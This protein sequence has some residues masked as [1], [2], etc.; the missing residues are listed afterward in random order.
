METVTY[1]VYTAP[2]R[3][4]SYI[5]LPA[6]GMEDIALIIALLR[7]GFDI[8]FIRCLYA[9]IHQWSSTYQQIDGTTITVKEYGRYDANISNIPLPSPTKYSLTDIH[10]STTKK[11]IFAAKYTIKE[12]H[13]ILNITPPESHKAQ[14]KVINWDT[15]AES[16]EIFIELL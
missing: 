3:R 7:Q 6:H 9:G 12:I 16:P 15:I 4:C 11:Q 8:Q 1:T 5:N 10:I 2:I 13:K 14:K